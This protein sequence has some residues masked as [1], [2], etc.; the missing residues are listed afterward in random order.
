M[1]RFRKTTYDPPWKEEHSRLA[2]AD[3]NGNSFTIH[4]L[5][6]ARYAT[7][8]APL[9][10]DWTEKEV[11]LADLKDVWF[12]K[13]VFAPPGIAHTFLSFDFGDDDPIVISVEA[14]QRPGQKY[15]PF[16]G[17]LQEF[18][19]IYVVGDERDIIGVRTYSKKNEIHF[20]PTTFP[21]DRSKRLF[22]DMMSRTNELVAQPKH[23]NT[24][25]ANCT[26]S[27][28]RETIV[29]WWQRYFDWRLIL[30]GFSDRVAY[31]Y[32]AL[33]QEHPVKALRAAAHLN[34][35]DALP[36]EPDFSKRIRESFWRRLGRMPP[37]PDPRPE[38]PASPQ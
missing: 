13:S 27:L 3:I 21:P 26:I 1:A 5:R 23:Y 25:A 31:K 9:S 12:G 33:I 20:Q 16:T 30:S 32:G 28:A 24:L 36:H 11:D 4:N 15:H 19:L 7:N 17:L 14:R 6:R 8:A 2:S 22:L 37:T 18:H 38:T 10:V 35:D 34:P 29:P